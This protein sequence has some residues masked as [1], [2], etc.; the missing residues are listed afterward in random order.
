MSKS[1][2][3][4]TMELYL[5]AAGMTYSAEYGFHPT[6]RWRFDFAIPTERIAIEVEGGVW[7]GG[8]HGTGSGFSADCEKYNAAT[9]EGWSVLRYTSKTLHECI[10]DIALLLN[11]RRTKFALQSQPRQDSQS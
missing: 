3:E 2:L 10:A 4:V 8:R 5:K 6:R 9:I 1:K 7:S 11:R